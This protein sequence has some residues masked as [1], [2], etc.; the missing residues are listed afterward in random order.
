MAPQPL[1]SVGR[2]AKPVFDPI[3]ADKRPELAAL[4]AKSIAISAS[5]EHHM[6]GIIA[7]MLGPN[8]QPAAAMYMSLRAAPVQR[9][10]MEAVAEAVLPPHDQRLFG[11]V[12]EIASAANSDRNR[13]AH[14]IWGYAEDLPYSLLFL[15]PKARRSFEIDYAMARQAA[16]AGDNSL[17]TSLQH[18]GASIL[19][20]RKSDFEESVTKLLRAR[21]IVASFREMIA[22]RE[23]HD[24]L[25]ER[26]TS[27]P[28]VAAE[29]ARLDRNQRGTR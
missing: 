22:L 19:A 16:R 12:R 11:A 3:A 23:L 2:N 9:D 24:P 1:S 10:A 28:E 8:A 18:D 26:L 27:Q 21:L 14:W 25:Y 4:A 6:V 15:D 13:F 7:E 17:L 5:I 29:M 20:Y